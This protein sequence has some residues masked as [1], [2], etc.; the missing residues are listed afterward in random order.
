MQADKLLASVLF[1]DERS[2]NLLRQLQPSSC[3]LALCFV[4]GPIR[5]AQHTD[6]QLGGYEGTPTN[7]AELTF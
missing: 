4:E 1:A 5:L 2:N 3:T 7:K 6:D